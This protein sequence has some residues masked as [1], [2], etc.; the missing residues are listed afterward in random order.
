VLNPIQGFEGKESAGIGSDEGEGRVHHKWVRAMRC[1]LK[2][3]F[4]HY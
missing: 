1:P 2:L 3:D 4:E